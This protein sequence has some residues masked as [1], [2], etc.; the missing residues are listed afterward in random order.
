MK[1]LPHDKVVFFYDIEGVDAYHATNDQM[2][3]YLYAVEGG[4]TVN[5]E[6]VQCDDDTEYIVVTFADIKAW[7]DTW[8][9]VDDEYVYDDVHDYI[10]DCIG[11]GF[12]IVRLKEVR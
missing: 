5:G 7:F 6:N 2:E 11:N 12:H 8:D 1:V 10:A 4:W 9:Q 3:T